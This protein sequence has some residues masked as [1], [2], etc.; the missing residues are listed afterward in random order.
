LLLRNREIGIFNNLPLTI[1]IGN[2]GSSE[3]IAIELMD[4]NQHR[5]VL[6]PYIDLDK[7][8]HINIGSSFTDFFTR[9]DNG[10]DWF[11]KETFIQ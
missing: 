11:S 9:L 10:R 6:S 8:Y 5:I 2:N 3:F 7:E 1:A 4:D